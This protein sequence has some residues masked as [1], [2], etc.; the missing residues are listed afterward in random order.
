MANCGGYNPDKKNISNFLDLIG[1]E[2][3][4]F[5][6]QYENIILLGDFNSEM[7]EETMKD[8]C[9]TY[10]LA[11]LIK[12]PTCFKSI[13]NPSCIDVI[14]T[15]RNLCFESSTTIE[16]G[17]SGCHKMTVTVMKKHYK[18]LEPIKIEYRDYKFFKY[19]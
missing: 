4:K 17:L 11:N 6:P 9:E 18:K 14:L 7:S 3:D 12:D 5:L 13:E 2:L 8:F 1:K 16:T 19:I 10:N 15:N